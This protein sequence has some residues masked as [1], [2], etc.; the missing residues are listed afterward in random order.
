MI[1]DLGIWLSDELEMADNAYY[2]QTAYSKATS[3]CGF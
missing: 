2:E 3:S 1:L